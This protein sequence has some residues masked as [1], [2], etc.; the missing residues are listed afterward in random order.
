MPHG[1]PYKGPLGAFNN[2]HDFSIHQLQMVDNTTG[3]Q[4]MKEFAKHTI[5]GAEL[6]S[7]ARDPPPRC[8]PGTRQ[9]TIG[10]MQLWLRNLDHSKKRWLW[11]VG[12]AGVGKSAIMQ[13]I[14]E[15]EVES[16][17]DLSKVF[18][19]VGYQLAV[20]HS[21]YRDYMRAKIDAN[22]K[23][24]GKALDKQFVDFIV[25]P[26]AIQHLY[27][28][29]KPIL[30]FIDG[31]DECR[32]QSD[33][34]RL[35][36]LISSF[37]TT[38]PNAPLRWVV[39]SRPEAHIQNHLSKAKIASTFEKEELPVDSTEACKDVERY[40]RFQMVEIRDSDPVVRTL[41]PHWPLEHQLLKLFA[42]T[43]GLF[44]YA[45]TVV[46]YIKE[47]NIVSRFQLVLEL[48]ERSSPDSRIDMTQPMAR[49]DA[50][51]Y[52]IISQVAPDDLPHTTEIL[53]FIIYPP[54]VQRAD[55]PNKAIVDNL[56]Q[57]FMCDWLGMSPGTMYSALRQ[58]HS[59]LDVPPPDDY[60]QVRGYH[61]SFF[62]FLQLRMQPSLGLPVNQAEGLRQHHRSL[63]RILNRFPLTDS[64]TS[65]RPPI[66]TLLFWPYPDLEEP[67]ARERLMGSL[68]DI[69]VVSGGPFNTPTISFDLIH[70]AKVVPEVCRMVY[71]RVFA[72]TVLSKHFQQDGRLQAIPVRLL[73]LDMID[74]TRLELRWEDT[75]DV[76]KMHEEELEYFRFAQTSSPECLVKAFIGN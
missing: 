60:K 64:A 75:I 33:Q 43:L 14:A 27:R 46:R 45:E 41:Y 70:A 40:L 22:P 47:T 52:H 12:P 7:S 18:T 44:A 38:Y 36:D 20:Q 19:T 50:L 39:A 61:K 66:Q 55:L 42:A 32:E 2:A 37:S 76:L 57:A 3:D 23:L 58:L 30:V 17:N 68:N 24:F 15:L 9:G 25:E 11:L 69:C 31:L 6:D 59:V 16:Q 54:I 74:E 72:G 26:F 73:D 51:Y 8:H 4:F 49:L 29:S 67:F 53:S 21:A 71:P 1:S 5:P 13:S 63:I 62:D 10:R 65:P 34:L 28:E 35:L 48:V 56:D